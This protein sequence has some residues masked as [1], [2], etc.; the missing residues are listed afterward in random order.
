MIRLEQALVRLNADLTELSLRWALVGGLAVSVRAEPRTTRDLDVAIAVGGDREAE[1]IALAFKIR[2]YRE[3]AAGAVLEHKDK[4]RLATV[5]FLLPDEEEIAIGVDLLFASSGV[6]EEITAA[7]EMRRILPSLYVP[8][9]RIGHLIALKVLAGRDKDRAD[10]R[11]LLEHSERDDLQLARQ[12]LE[13]ITARG[14]NRGKDLL[15]ELTKLEI[16]ED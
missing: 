11:L 1:R 9:A 5:R 16:P 7:A 3:H 2:G 8:V 14:F 12:T 10:V 15:A 13:L 6:E 4:E